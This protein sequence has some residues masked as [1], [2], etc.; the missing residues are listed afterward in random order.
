MTVRICSPQHAACGFDGWVIRR[1][2]MD[3]LVPQ[4]HEPPPVR[5]VAYQGRVCAECTEGVNPRILAG[6]LSRTTDLNHQIPGE[7]A[8]HQSGF[9]PLGHE[10]SAVTE[11]SHTDDSGELFTE[12]GRGGLQSDA[13]RGLAPDRLHAGGDSQNGC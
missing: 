7:V 3:N 11:L 1:E 6:A 2:N 9:E 4:E 8:H 10:D 13:Q 12:A 5:P